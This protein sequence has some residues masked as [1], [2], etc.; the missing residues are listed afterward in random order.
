MLAA[1]DGINADCLRSNVFCVAALVAFSAFLFWLTHRVT[2]PKAPLRIQ[3]CEAWLKLRF[4]RIERSVSR[5]ADVSAACY[6]IANAKG[7]G[8]KTHCC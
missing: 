1:L 4:K 7:K 3:G 8:A 5:L 6:V 2:I